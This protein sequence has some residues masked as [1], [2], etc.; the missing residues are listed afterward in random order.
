MAPPAARTSINHSPLDG[1]IRRSGGDFSPVVSSGG[2][3]CARAFFGMTSDVSHR[4][5]LVEF[6]AKQRLEKSQQA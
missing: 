4:E 3:F 6:S 2:A 5:L 1:F